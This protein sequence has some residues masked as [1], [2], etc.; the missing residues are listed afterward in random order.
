MFFEKYKRPIMLAVALFALL[1]FSISGAVYAFFGDLATRRRAGQITL[2]DGR[3]VTLSEEDYQVGRMLYHLHAQP[4]LAFIF[5]A[6]N[7]KETREIGGLGYAI[8]R[9]AALESGLDVSDAEVAAAVNYSLR[10][11]QTKLR[12]GPPLPRPT[13]LQLAQRLG[14]GGERTLYELIREALRITTFVRMEL[15]GAVDLGDAA[16]AEYLKKKRKR[17][18]LSYVPFRADDCQKLLEAS[19]PSNEKLRSWI[20]ELG[21]D[22]PIKTPFVDAVHASF[23]G[24]ALLYD[25][26]DPAGFDKE[27]AGRVIGDADIEARYNEDRELL[28][29]RP[30]PET[31]DGKKGEKGDKGEKEAGSGSGKENGKDEDGGLLRIGQEEAGKQDGPPL[32]ESQDVQPPPDPYIPLDEVR[33]QIQKKLQLEAVLESLL[34]SARSAYEESLKKDEKDEEEKNP[35]AKE[36]EKDKQKGDEKAPEEQE[37][38]EKEPEPFELRSWFDGVLEGRAGLIFLE[39]GEVRPPER[40][41]ELAQLGRWN[42]HWT[43]SEVKEKELSSNIQRCE[44]G[45]FFFQVK[46]RKEKVLKK[47]EEIRTDALDAYYKKTSMD[48][49]KQK[50]EEW[51]K[52]VREK[53]EVIKEEEIDEKR[54]ELDKK[55]DELFEQWKKDQDAEIKQKTEDLAK[56]IVPINLIDQ[57]QKSIEDMK[58]A[59]E[60]GHKKKDE[61]RAKEDEELEKGIVELIEPALARGFDQAAQDSKLE[62]VHLVPF[63]IDE[64][65][66]PMFQTREEGAS[67]FLKSNKEILEAK[68]GWVSDALEDLGKTRAYYVV[69]VNKVTDGGEEA[70]TRYDMARKRPEFSK[71]RL[72]SVLRYGYSLD[73]LKLR[74]EYVEAKVEG[75]PEKGGPE[76]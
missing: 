5:A 14:L 17:L 74:Y 71:D 7:E 31:G 28:Y 9:R 70:V 27:L 54:A 41:R 11:G 50:A 10:E 15:L 40:Y 66:H 56:G 33:E 73:A 13:H 1:T 3:E 61:L 36:E 22:D 47:I 16:L 26:A 23:E 65:D 43:L 35:G 53:A 6:L 37:N 75:G 68:E 29:R 4:T 42:A 19:P 67:A 59:L 38:D 48:Q 58:K 12:R 24:V 39:A 18:G 32:G 55:V 60:D 34:A 20:E 44:K 63:F 72:K 76:K 51:R 21:E 30:V 45:A 25:V 62:V 2:E 69:R 57:V 64:K 52:L 46:E 8:L 49:A